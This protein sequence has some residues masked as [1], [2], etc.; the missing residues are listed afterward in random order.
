MRA[1]A[2]PVRD[3]TVRK[4]LSGPRR[5]LLSSSVAQDI[6]LIVGSSFS[7]AA[8]GLLLLLPLLRPREHVCGRRR[9]AR[10]R[11]PS[12]FLTLLLGL[13]SQ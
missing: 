5:M 13:A 1:A 3:S 4:E 12:A 9:T 10:G 8:S 6:P 11:E 7:G 2:L